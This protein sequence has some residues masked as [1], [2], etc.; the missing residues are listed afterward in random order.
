MPSSGSSIFTNVAGYQASLQDMLDLLVP[1]PTDFHARLTWVELADAHLLRAQE[2]SA[3]VAYATLPT[4][5][6]FVTFLIR[7]GTPLIHNGNELQFGK[8]LFHSPGEHAHQRTAGPT[9]WGSVAVT[10]R[11]L[12]AS[13]RTIVG[14]DLAAPPTS[15]VLRPRPANLRRLLRCHAQ[16]ARLAERDLA[17]IAN[18]EIARALEHDMIWALVTCLATSSVLE[19]RTT[20]RRRAQLSMRLERILT[21]DPTRLRRTAEIADALGISEAMLR[22]DCLA[23]LGM[24]IARYQRLRRLERVYSALLRASATANGGVEIIKRHGFDN[25]QRFVTEYWQAF[26]EMPPMPRRDPPPR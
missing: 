17:S 16:A 23:L 20:D 21:T 11:T 2:G 15:Q 12:M 4:D 7:Q 10:P 5:R 1:N 8:L 13:S 18:Q 14:R 24:S 22:A 25:I 6:S 26:G 19:D 3:R 9:N